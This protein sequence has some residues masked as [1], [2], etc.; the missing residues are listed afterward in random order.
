MEGQRFPALNEISDLMGRHIEV[1]KSTG[2][3]VVGWF[4]SYTP[5]EILQA[6][7]LHPLRIV[8]EPGRA[9][10]R[11]DTYIDRNFCPY[12]RTCLGEA[13]D[14]Y[15]SFLDGLV[16]VNSCDPMRR[17]YDTW[18]YYVGGDFI[19]LLDL[20]RVDTDS[21]VAYYRERLEDFKAE[22]EKHFKVKVSDEMLSDTIAVQNRNRSL[23]KEL[24]LL[25][26]NKGM[27][28][29]ATQVQA[30]IRAG[31]VLPA[32]VYT[33]L[34]EQLLR[35]VDSSDDGRSDGPRLLITGSILDNPQIIGLV[36]EYGAH[37]V[38]D[39]LCTGTRRFWDTAE[40]EDD[41][42]TA[43]SSHYLNRIPCPRMK[44]SLRRFDHIFRMIGDLRVNGVIFY[45]LKFCDPFLFDVPVLKG[46]L[47]DKGIPNL[48]L[49]GDY[50]PGTLGR[51]K[52]RI[53]AFVEMLRQDVRAI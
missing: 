35:D 22:I 8:P 47:D 52:T 28:L 41:P 29:P 27:P 31:T 37:M 50:S 30:V 7:G 44:E 32:E 53:E 20:P 33:G 38:G 4:C 2:K 6:A 24:Y 1:V 3:P 45:T 16:V 9:M 5:L 23:L 19:Q 36:E 13:L 17:L 11:A 46:L 49:E 26:I 18:R 42:L 15:Y 48:V 14:G 12:V 25:N 43:L 39:D 34:L 40:A 51:V 10:T 21:A